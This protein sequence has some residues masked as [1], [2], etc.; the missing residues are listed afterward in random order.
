[1]DLPIVINGTDLRSG[2]VITPDELMRAR[3][4]RLPRWRRIYGRLPGGASYWIGKDPRIAF[5][6]GSIEI[7]ACRHSYLD[8]DRQWRTA[9]LLSEREGHLEWLDVQIID[10]VYAATNLYERFRDS[11]AIHL[12]NPDRDDENEVIWQ[13]PT[14]HVRA[15]LAPDLLHSSF[16]LE[17]P[18]DNGHHAVPPR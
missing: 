17:W 1:M 9:L 8:I 16:R 15:C 7:Y 18:R 5:F 14:L 6:D 3:L 13:R 12:G 2:Q 11:A 4:R 10:G